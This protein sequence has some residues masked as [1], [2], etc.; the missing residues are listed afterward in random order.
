MTDLWTKSLCHYPGVG[1]A[2]T[3]TEVKLRNHGDG[4]TTLDTVLTLN[5]GQMKLISSC[6]SRLRRQQEGVR[7][8]AWYLRLGLVELARSCF[9]IV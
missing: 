3:C 2:K 1:R 5:E 4:D 6:L 9:Q 7:H 8:L